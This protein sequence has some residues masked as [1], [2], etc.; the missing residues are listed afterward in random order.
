MHLVRDEHLLGAGIGADLS[1]SPTMIGI[2]RAA[3]QIS[4][5]EQAVARCS[6]STP[7]IR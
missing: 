4:C 3:R 2:T 1:E 7:V 6:V 5:P